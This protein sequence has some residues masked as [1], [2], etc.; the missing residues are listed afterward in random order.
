MPGSFAMLAAA[1]PEIELGAGFVLPA[2]FEMFVFDYRRARVRPRGS[3]GGL[4]RT[5]IMVGRRFRGWQGGG[6]REVVYLQGLFMRM[7]GMGRI[8]RS[9]GE[10][11]E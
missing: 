4:G 10:R 6:V 8:F 2:I 3:W 9:G 11:T 1:L 5:V 7:T